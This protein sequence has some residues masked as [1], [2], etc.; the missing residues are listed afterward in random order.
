MRL[1][2][3]AASAFVFFAF[4]AAAL[5]CSPETTADPDAAVCDPDSGTNCGCDPNTYKPSDCYTGPKGTNGKGACK[6]GK[7]TCVNGVLSACV[8]EVLPTPEVC[9]YADN[10]CN[11]VTDDLEAFT[12]AEPI[13]YC[14]SPAC[15]PT[16]RDA[17]IYCFGGGG[18]GICG[19]GKKTCAPGPSGGTPNGCEPFIKQGAPEECNG[20]DDDCNGSVDDGLVGT[21]GTCKVT[22]KK[23]ECGKG[24][25]DCVD[26]G[27][28]CTQ[29]TFPVAETCNAKDDDCDG[30]IDN[31]GICAAG[32][33]C[34][35]YTNSSFAY[36]ETSTWW[37]SYDI[38]N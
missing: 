24:E 1:K 6:L 3:F 34:C 10:D 12:D 22:N 21:L 32:E 28:A 31:I 30:I 36:C 38:C 29:V 35:R 27:V 8:G 5:H 11:G 16:Y 19:A 2:T 37:N 7:R 25:N 23:G 15:D 17:A 26:G 4:G 14:E 18:V 20:I 33:K 9:D 13:A